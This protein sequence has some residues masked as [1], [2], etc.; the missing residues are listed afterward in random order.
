MK[1][2]TVT[3]YLELSIQNMENLLPKQNY[4][5]LNLI[6]HLIQDESGTNLIFDFL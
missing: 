2:E 6:L 5:F 3:Q 4:Y 1:P